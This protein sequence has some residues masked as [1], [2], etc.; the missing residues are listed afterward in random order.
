MGVP[1]G[2]EAIV[3]AVNCVQEDTNIK[4]EDKLSLLQDF[5]NAFNSISHE[6]M[7]REVR[8]RI[9]SMTAWLECCYGAK[10]L[11]HFGNHIILSCCGVQQGDPLGPL[12]FSL[13]LHPIVE[14]IKREV[15]GLLINAWYLDD[16]TLCG[17][18]DDLKAALEIIEE[19]GLSRGLQLNR[20]KSLLYIPE[21]S[22]SARNP[23][24][25]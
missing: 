18:A 10:P 2:C 5:T 1:L 22:A 13:A 11:L 25:P 8:S 3:H 24:P 17:T 4:S 16:G 7:F 6:Q 23:L 19:D 14:R 21:D 12:A 15:P 9:P 20:G